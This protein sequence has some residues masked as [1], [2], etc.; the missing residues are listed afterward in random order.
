[1]I[2]AYNLQALINCLR[3]RGKKLHS[4]DFLNLQNEEEKMKIYCV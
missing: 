4:A 2:R 1:M 3:R